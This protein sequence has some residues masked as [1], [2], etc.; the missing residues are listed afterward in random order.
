[1]A[2]DW[3]KIEFCLPRKPEVWHL[4]ALLN[5]DTA[6]VVGKLFQFWCWFNEHTEDGNAPSVTVP[7]LDEHVGVT[8]FCNAMIE[9]GWL[10]QEDSMITL[11][12]FDRHNGKTAK[13]RALTNQR[14]KRSRNA[15]TVT[16]ALPEKRREEK[17]V[18]SDLFNDFWNIYPRKT[19]KAQAGKAFERLNPKADLLALITKDIQRRLASEEW[20]LTDKQHIPHA[21]TYLNGARWEDEP[22]ASGKNYQELVL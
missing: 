17:N 7:L 12:N 6:T 1:M 16:K 9:V 19:N 18:Y 20:S 3:I 22:L 2:G 21:S 5:L 15:D 11:P 8:G 13:K 4:V 14:V 10:V